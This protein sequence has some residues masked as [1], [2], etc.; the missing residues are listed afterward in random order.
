M[1]VR[2][3]VPQ[4][5]VPLGP[6]GK[7]MERAERFLVIPDGPDQDH[8]VEHYERAGLRREGQNR[9]T[10]DEDN[11]LLAD[12]IGDQP[13]PQDVAISRSNIAE[14]GSSSTPAKKTAAK[15]AVTRDDAKG[16]D[17]A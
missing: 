5:S 11:P 9:P 6:D 17:N 4:M 15:A 13:F 16:N 12:P 2:F 8:L 1:T 14:D 10:R 3:Q 7:P